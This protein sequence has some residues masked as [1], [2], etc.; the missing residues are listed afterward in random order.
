L[1]ITD[2]MAPER[3]EEIRAAID[4]GYAGP[5]KDAEQSVQ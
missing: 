2:D 4:A 3:I 1:I 5:P